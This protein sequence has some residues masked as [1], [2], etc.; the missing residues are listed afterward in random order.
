MEFWNIG[1]QTLSCFDFS[2]PLLVTHSGISRVF[3]I[4]LSATLHS[5]SFMKKTKCLRSKIRV[6]ESKIYI[7]EVPTKHGSPLQ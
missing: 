7:S 4:G 1:M 2:N 3:D 5:I 6:R